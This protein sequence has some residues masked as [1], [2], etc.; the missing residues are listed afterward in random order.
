MYRR[1]GMSKYQ[2]SGLKRKQLSQ[3]DIDKKYAVTD[4]IYVHLLT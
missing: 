4:T 1:P 3:W 2:L